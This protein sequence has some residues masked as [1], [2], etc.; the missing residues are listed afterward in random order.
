MFTFL[1]QILRFDP[2]V[3]NEK[4]WDLNTNQYQLQL[5]YCNGSQYIKS[6]PM[7]QKQN[8]KA[9]IHTH[10]LANQTN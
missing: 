3:E 5:L 2:S 6:S 1:R 8:F 10:S 7:G 9:L 4:L